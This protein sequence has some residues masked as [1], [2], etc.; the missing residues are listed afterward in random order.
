[1]KKLLIAT[2]AAVLLGAPL[3]LAANTTNGTVV[4]AK[5]ATAHI[6]TESPSDQCNTLGTQFDK[7]EATHKTNK[8]WKDALALRNEGKTLCTSHKETDGVKKIE[9]ALKMIGLKPALKS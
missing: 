5:P 1:M 3:A 8:H 7:A 2:A 6:A 4:P 9:S